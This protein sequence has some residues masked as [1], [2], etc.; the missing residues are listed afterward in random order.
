MKRYSIHD[1]DVPIKSPTLMTICRYFSCPHYISLSIKYKNESFTDTS[2][3][4]CFAKKKDL[5][6]WKKSNDSVY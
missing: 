1:A 6:K 3:G 2:L 5:K 4:L